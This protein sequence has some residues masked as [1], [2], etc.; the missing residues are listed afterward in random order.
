MMPIAK[1]GADTLA[2]KQASHRACN[3]AKKDKLDY[4]HTVE[5]EF[6]EFVTARTW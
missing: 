1:G 3:Q 2:N 5:P 6:R 4:E